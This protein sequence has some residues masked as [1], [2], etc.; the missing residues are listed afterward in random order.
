MHK[1]LQQAEQLIASKIEAEQGIEKARLNLEQLEQL[2]SEMHQ[3]EEQVQ[4]IT[5][6]SA[7]LKA[8][9]E[10]LSQQISKWHREISLIGEAD[11]VCPL[12]RRPLSN[13]HAAALLADL[14]TQKGEGEARQKAITA[15]K[16]RLDREKRTLKQKIKRNREA[17]SQRHN[18]ERVLARAEA[19]RRQAEETAKEAEQIRLQLAE[20][21]TVLSEERYAEK[22]RAGQA[23]V[24]AKIAALNY[25]ENAHR[26]IRE[27]V[28]KLQKFREQGETL[29]LARQRLQQ[30]EAN[31][32]G[33]TERLHALQEESAAD[34]QQREQLEKVLADRPAVEKE[35]ADLSLHLRALEAQDSN[36]KLRLG[37]A[38]QELR[39]LEHAEQKLQEGQKQL[40]R[41][42]EE[43]ALYQELAAAFG[44]KG[45]QALL[46]ESVVPE[47][48]EEANH[49]LHKMTNGR[50]SV[51]ME[52]QRETKS[53]TVQ[54]TLQIIIADEVGPRNYE[55]YSGGEAFRVNFALRVAL[56]RLL[57]RRAGAQ[58][59]TL[60][61]DEGFGSQDS[62]GR[63]RL[64]ETIN[65]IS[66]EFDQILV[67]THIEELREMFPVH[68]DVRKGQHGS[69]AIVN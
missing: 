22:A 49:L 27:S 63:Q 23:A 37:A 51:Q 40:N 38:Q 61:V 19:A 3:A 29:R 34:R 16:R 24:E 13:D 14:Q 64:I 15:Q 44:K 2:E 7:G 35:L 50:L 26:K 69:I 47:I 12:C 67:I 31:Q 39:A 17:L 46:I 32:Q 18:W 1:Q 58:L 56:S 33:D 9:A 55:M 25:D 66:Q 4:A 52:T 45:V 28:D 20:I 11:Q 54:E 36:I 5:T 68:I 6:A 41:L 62:Q 30:E 42:V 8:E 48:E 43:V 10:Q 53:G 60:F 57:A 59:R 21:E 65:S